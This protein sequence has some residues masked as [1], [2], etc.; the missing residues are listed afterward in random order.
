M[1][2]IIGVSTEDE[3]SIRP[4]LKLSTGLIKRTSDHD[5]PAMLATGPAI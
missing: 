2:V 1:F 3:I 5:Q 4:H